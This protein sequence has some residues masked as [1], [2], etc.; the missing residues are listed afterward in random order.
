MKRICTPT[1]GADDWQQFLADPE[2]QWKTGFSARTL[3]YAWEEADGFP[4]TVQTVLQQSFP[5]IEPLIIL[6][7]H[8]VALPGRGGA[9]QND[10]WALG[11]S[12]GELVSIAVEGKVAE[13]FG[14]TV[15]QWNPDAGAGRQ[16]RFDFLKRMLQLEDIPSSI[17]YQLLHRTV[18]ALLEAERFN[19]QHA[20]L[21]IHSFS[22]ENLW[23]EDFA[24]LVHLFGQ[25][26]Q[27]DQ[28]VR[29][30]GDRFPALHFAWVHGNE[31]YLSR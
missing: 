5:A 19:A 6:P 13:P 30:D 16:M 11:S 3:A 31:T 9:S 20:V 21:L 7:E 26:A 29:A 12:D 1:R 17:R 10:V 25:A 8:K 15:G 18:S 2:K 27:V 24:G 14:L 28:I 23:F 22:Q 4:A